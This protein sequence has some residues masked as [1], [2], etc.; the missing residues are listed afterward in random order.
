MIRPAMEKDHAAA[1]HLMLQL[2]SHPFT[3]EQF[4]ECYLYHLNHHTVLICEQ[5]G[6]VCGLGV[7][8]IHYPLH[9]SGKC[10][11]IDNLIV[12]ETVRG[13]GVGKELLSAMEQIAIAHGCVRLEVSS[14]RWR[15]DAHRFY[16]R[17]GFENTHLKLTKPLE[18]SADHAKTVSWN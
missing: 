1:L 14:G 11:E 12:D 15:K 7:L 18:W 4:R 16:Q 10:A 9:F 13:Q 6:V 3:K 17:E 5:A 8:S 2:S